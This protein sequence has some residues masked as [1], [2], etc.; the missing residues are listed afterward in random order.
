MRIDIPIKQLQQIIVLFSSYCNKP[1]LSNKASILGSLP[2]N[3]LYNSIGS[4][5]LPLESTFSLKDNQIQQINFRIRMIRILRLLNTHI[6]IRQMLMILSYTTQK[7]P[8]KISN[9]QG[10]RGFLKRICPNS[11][12][13]TFSCPPTG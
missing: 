12:A 8:L 2:L 6:T 10:T 3:F 7:F 1:S 13:Q 11:S 5:R 9:Q 4:S